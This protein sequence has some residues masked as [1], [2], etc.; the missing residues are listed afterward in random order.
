MSDV[1]VVDVIHSE[2]GGKGSK[3]SKKKDDK[4]DDKKK[5]DKKDDKKKDDKDKKDAAGT[6]AGAAGTGAAG[7]GAAGTGKESCPPG[8]Q[9]VT[10]SVS[11]RLQATADEWKNTGEKINNA[12]E[13]AG[14]KASGALKATFVNPA[15]CAAG[16]ASSIPAIAEKV[17]DVVLGKMDQAA[18]SAINLRSKI[19]DIALDDDGFPNVL[20]PFQI[21]YLSTIKKIQG[22]FG[23]M[24]FGKEN[25]PKILADPNMDTGKLTADM[26]QASTAFKNVVDSPGFQ[27]IFKEW[28]SNYADSLDK[29]IQMGKPKIDGVTNKLTGMIDDTSNKLGA[30]FTDSLSNVI[31]AALKS[32]P[33]VG[34]I[35]NV[36]ELA[37]KMAASLIS[38]CEPIISKGGLSL[39]TLANAGVKQAKNADCKVKELTDKLAS[40]MP[41][42]KQ[43]GGFGRT[44]KHRFDNRKKIM[45]ATKRVK[46]MLHRFTKRPQLK[47]DYASKYRTRRIRTRRN[48]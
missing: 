31:G 20:A 3:G 8:A 35:F 17:I 18:E 23:N 45:Q 1:S 7:T 36:G 29:A 47:L 40:L 21:V 16:A 12:M 44:H 25:W 48:H 26:L 39:I 33:G 28:L 43:H 30:A 19:I 37:S 41:G 42:S 32:I 4:K 22:L 6:D 27:N 15:V 46:Y 2:T 10:Q 5:D 34:V 13:H 9:C 14:E 11:A 24:V 38:V